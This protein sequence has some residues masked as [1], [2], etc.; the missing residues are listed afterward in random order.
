[1]LK[2]NVCK[3]SDLVTS[4]ACSSANLCSQHLAWLHANKIWN[5]LER[6]GKLKETKIQSILHF[7]W[8][9]I[10]KKRS[11]NWRS[12]KVTM[13]HLKGLLRL[14]VWNIS[15]QTYLNVKRSSREKKFWIFG[16]LTS[17]FW[18]R[19]ELHSTFTKHKYF[20]NLI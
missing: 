3:Y 8:L 15:F 6:F 9:Y 19:L 13:Y 17:F 20:M 12:I 2:W 1:M 10:E 11:G 14:K 16:T 5:R 7:N 4:E 18:N